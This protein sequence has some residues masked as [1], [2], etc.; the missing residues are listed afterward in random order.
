MPFVVDFNSLNVKNISYDVS[1]YGKICCVLWGG[2]RLALKA[3]MSVPQQE[4]GFLQS[5]ATWWQKRMLHQSCVSLFAVYAATLKPPICL[6]PSGATFVF[7]LDSAAQ[8][9]ALHRY[10]GQPARRLQPIERLVFWL[11]LLLHPVLEGKNPLQLPYILSANLRGKC[12]AWRTRGSW[13]YVM[14]HL[15]DKPL[16]LDWNLV[17]VIGSTERSDGTRR[18]ANSLVM[19]P[20]RWINSVEGKL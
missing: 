14:Y 20:T 18:M 10:Q 5:T 8:S 3:I 2:T 1:H 17:I 11:K 13:I 19:F 12:H 9:E 16:G 15:V 7:H 4:G 6:C